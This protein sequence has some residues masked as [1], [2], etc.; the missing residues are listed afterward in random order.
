[1]SRTNG[2]SKVQKWEITICFQHLGGPDVQLME[3]DNAS[4][5]YSLRYKRGKKPQ[6][7]GNTAAAPILDGLITWNATT[8]FQS[9]LLV[10][11]QGAFVRKSLRLVLLQHIGAKIAPIGKEMLVDL[12]KYT[13]SGPKTWAFPV[14]I[15]GKGARLQARFQCTNLVDRPT[16]ISMSESENDPDD[17]TTLGSE[18]ASE[19]SVTSPEKRKEKQRTEPQLI[20]APIGLSESRSI[21][22]SSHVPEA[23]VQENGSDQETRF[24]DSSRHS[25]A[26][27]RRDDISQ[28]TARTK[29][30][31]AELRRREREFQDERR[32][33]K[34]L[35]RQL[36][37]TATSGDVAQI[38][39]LNSENKRFK[40]LLEEER[41]EKAR[42]QQDAY[43]QADR[44][45]QQVLEQ[46]Q[47]YEAAQRALN[48]ERAK[49]NPVPERHFCS[50]CAVQ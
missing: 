12:A 31:E 24:S 19:A 39:R 5:S 15:L 27:L 38:G 42:L 9:S 11:A 40:E 8:T 48:R 25:S 13:R 46:N 3:L 49:S 23:D 10:N 32:R 16:S 47:M 37:E 34:E 36:E 30:L 20:E 33:R 50:D 7:T 14:N 29:R 18:T 4:A 2:L 43:A 45:K 35:E 1:M 22:P 41:R 6:N 28:S 26:S 44:L 21:L 17:L